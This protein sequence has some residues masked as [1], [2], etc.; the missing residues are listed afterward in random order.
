ME[1][2]KYL[3]SAVQ[4]NGILS[5]LLLSEAA[6]F[7]ASAS[8]A[9]LF[10]TGD[11]IKVSRSRGGLFLPAIFGIFLGRPERSSCSWRLGRVAFPVFQFKSCFS[12]GLGVNVP[13]LPPR[14]GKETRNTRS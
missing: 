6:L 4:M 1:K 10:A 3:E 12:S 5:D 2:R 8:D 9:T 11:A 14:G 13:S 7:C